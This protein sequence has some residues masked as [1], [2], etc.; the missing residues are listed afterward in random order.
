V[1]ALS[2]K[3]QGRKLL[4]HS[5]KLPISTLVLLLKQWIPVEQ[6]TA[7]PFKML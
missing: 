7:H 1:A 4:P 6:T 3:I 2:S 5:S